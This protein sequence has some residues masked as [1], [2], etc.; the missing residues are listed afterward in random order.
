MKKQRRHYEDSFKRMAVDL[1]LTG[2]GTGEVADPGETLLSVLVVG[3]LQRA[4]VIRMRSGHFGQR[5]KSSER[6]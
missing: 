5:W 3:L 2:R 1:C 4:V 6:T